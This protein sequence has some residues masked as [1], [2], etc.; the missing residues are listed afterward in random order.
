MTVVCQLNVGEG[1]KSKLDN[2]GQRNLDSEEQKLGNGEEPKVGNGEQ[3]NVDIG[4]PNID[5]RGQPNVDGGQPNVHDGVQPNVDDGGRPNVHDGGLPNV[6]EPNGSNGETKSRSRTRCR[7]E[8]EWR[9]QNVRK[10]SRNKGLEYPTRKG[11]LVQVRNTIYHRCGRCV[12]KCN[13]IL[14]DDDRD[15]ICQNYWKMGDMQRQQDYL[16]NH[17]VIKAISRKTP[18]SRRNMTLHH[19]F[20]VQHKRV[21]V[22]KAVFLKTL[23]IGK[24]L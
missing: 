7:M 6:E 1:E 9:M 4:Q 20:T 17:V 2:G 18:G 5:D 3:P 12:N 23:C 15:T 14:S 24:K 10:M 21:K 13:D 11:T 22:C 8:S 19:F 16:A